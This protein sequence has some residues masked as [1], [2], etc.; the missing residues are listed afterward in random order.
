MARFAAV[1][2][3]SDSA[4]V[5]VVQLAFDVDGTACGEI[6]G[7][8]VGTSLDYHHRAYQ[9]N[10]G[11]EENL[12]GQSAGLV[13]EDSNKGTGVAGSA[14]EVAAAAGYA[15]E[16]V[17]GCVVGQVVAAGYFA[18]ELGVVEVG[19]L[20]LLELKKLAFAH[21]IYSVRISFYHNKR[22]CWN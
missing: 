4:V 22:K 20:V 18:V 9:D 19:L 14:G 21:S 1:V 17:A 6:H 8:V 12:A 11:Q 5:L 3:A 15:A 10:L 2:E 13:E 16:R 7:W